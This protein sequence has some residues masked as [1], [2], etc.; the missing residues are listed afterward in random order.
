MITRHCNA[1]FGRTCDTL[2]CSSYGDTCFLFRIRAQRHTS[3]HKIP[4]AFYD[5]HSIPTTLL[6]NNEIPGR[7]LGLSSCRC[8]GWVLQDT[9]S[10]VGELVY[11]VLNARYDVTAPWGGVQRV[12]N[13]VKNVAILRIHHRRNLSTLQTPDVNR[14]NMSPQLCPMV[15]SPRAFC[16]RAT[17]SIKP[18]IMRAI[19]P[20]AHHNRALMMVSEHRG[21]RN[22]SRHRRLTIVQT[23]TVSQ[24]ASNLRSK[25]LIS[26]ISS[27]TVRL[28]PT[29]FRTGGYHHTYL[30][31][32][33]QRRNIPRL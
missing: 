3:Y 31:Q 23:R 30:V 19:S 20:C 27:F 14:S 5:T 32:D 24:V 16:I 25:L 1:V 22:L 29:K 15:W 4:D 18:P 9:P 7:Y 17:R 10:P 12:L 13:E 21:A 28:M 26:Q 6:V 2:I 11:Y 33:R 8:H